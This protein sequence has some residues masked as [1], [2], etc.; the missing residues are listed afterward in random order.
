MDGREKNVRKTSSD[1]DYEDDDVAE[2][3]DENSA[4]SPETKPIHGSRYSPLT[5]QSEVSSGAS[6]TGT[7]TGTQNE[8]CVS[9]NCTKKRTSENAGKSSN[10]AG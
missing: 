3:S 2:D 8:G 7:Q 1:A 9:Q 5:F 4:N 6:P 10:D